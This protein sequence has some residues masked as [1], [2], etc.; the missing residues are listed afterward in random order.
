ME[1]NLTNLSLRAIQIRLFL[2]CWMIFVLHFATDFVREHYLVLSIVDDFSFRLDK[3]AD[4]HPDIFVIPGRGAYHGANPGASMIGAIP[5]FIFKPIIHRIAHYDPKAAPRPPSGEEI[6][7]EYKDPRPLRV[8]FYKQVRERGL[9]K[10]FGLVGFVTMAFAMA[11]LS[12][13]SAVMMFNTLGKL[14][15]SNQL[16]LGM[17]LL[18]ALGTPIFFRTGYLN[19]N[20]MVGSFAFIAF[21]LLW[22]PEERNPSRVRFRYI[23]AGFLGG[24]AFLCDYSGGIALFLVGCYGLLRRMDSVSFPQAFKDSLWYAVGAMG[25]VVLLWFYQWSCFGNP[26]YPPQHHMAP[27]EWMDVGYQGVGW[28]TKELTWRLL[29]DPQFGLF[30]ASPILLLAFFAPVLTHFKKNIL[31]ARETWFALIFFVA[32]LLF[33]GSVQYTR[34]QWNTGIRYIIPV[35]PFLFLLTVAVL[36]RMPRIWAYTFAVLA[37]AESWCMSMVRN[38]SFQTGILDS[39]IQ[40]FLQGFQLPWLTTLSKMAAQ[41]APFLENGGVSPL[42][43]FVLWGSLIYGIWRFKLPGEKVQKL[44]VPEK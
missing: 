8:K 1:M 12:A 4:L 6:S 3:Y 2:T 10:L 26:F 25:P 30:I 20:L 19:Q 34:L 33:F 42:P 28:P 18:Y 22:Q 37:F 24:L 15:L 35:I 5:Y 21:S 29:F 41:Y 9:D 14:G 38:Q 31:P 27:K 11:P 39:V 36:I 17:S 32:F 13:L 16:S 44:D 7:A 23:L 43:L 40:V